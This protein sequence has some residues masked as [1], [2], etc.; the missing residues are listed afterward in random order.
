[1]EISNKLRILFV[2]D[3]PSDTELAVREL[4]SAEIQFDYIRVETKD[5]FIAALDDFKP[6]FIISD[7][8]MPEFDGMQA[9]KLSLKHNPFLPFIIL[10]GSRNEDT[11]VACMKAGA[12]DYVIKGH[13]SRLPY[14]V[15]EAMERSLIIIER[16][17]AVQALQESEQN[18]KILADSGQ[19]LIWTSGTDKLCNY[20]NKTWLEF[21]GRTFEQENG[22]GWLEGVHPD[23]LSRCIEIYNSAFDR[24]ESFSMEYRLRHNDG[25]YRWIQDDGSPR[26][27]LSGEFIGYIGHCLDITDRKQNEEKIQQALKEKEALLRELYHRTRNNMQVII[28]ILS[29]QGDVYNNELVTTVVNETNNRIMSMSL[30]HQ[31][32]YQSQNLSSINLKDYVDELV[33]SISK[34]KNI[35]ADK[36]KVNVFADT[37]PVLIDTAVPLGLVLHEIVSNAFRHAFPGDAKGEVNIMIEQNKHGVIEITV[38]DNGIG[39]PDDFNFR[40]NDSLGFQ[41]IFDIVEEQLLGK[42]YFETNKG[43]TCHVLFKDMQYISRI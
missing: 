35:S 2:E 27:S 19:A 1:M 28:A 40:K 32:L 36:I 9:L 4:R 31:K 7:Y 11:A 16:E 21:T 3:L 5:A 25:N 26:Y 29:L 37:I 42:V 20:F 13:T 6:D 18:Y 10:T 43:L 23:D 30:V 34:S 8:S 33:V 17:A 24:R 12:T 39:M 41:I 15:Q 22:N 14:A 38:S